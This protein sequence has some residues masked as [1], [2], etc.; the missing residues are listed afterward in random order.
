MKQLN[1]ISTVAPPPSALLEEEEEEEEDGVDLD[2]DPGQD[3]L[4]VEPV[5]TGNQDPDYDSDESSPRYAAPVANGSLQAS[6]QVAA[7][8]A[9]V[10]EVPAEEGQV[11]SGRD[12]V[13]AVM[14]CQQL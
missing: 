3:G 12:D 9:A 6:P 10:P 11:R 13:L 5:G 4:P 1:V 8:V 14:S 7:V 2:L